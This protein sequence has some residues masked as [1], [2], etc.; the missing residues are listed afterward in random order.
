MSRKRRENADVYALR[1]RIVGLGETS[2]RKSHYPELQA[3]L[4]E[5]AASRDELDRTS[6]DL[7]RMVEELEEARRQAESNEER[8]RHIF[9]QATDGIVVVRLA[10]SRVVLANRQMARQLGCEPEFLVG[11]PAARLGL[12]AACREFV[13]EAPR[14]PCGTS[15]HL[16]GVT[17]PRFD[18]GSLEADVNAVLVEL[19][20]E[21]H[22][23]SIC[24][25]VGEQRRAELRL[26]QLSQ[27][28]E[29]SPAAVVITDGDGR[30]EYVNPAFTRMSGWSAEEVVGCGLERLHSGVT[31]DSVYED[32]HRTVSAGG[33]WRG[34]LCSQRR[35]GVRYW[36]DVTVAAIVDDDGRVIHHHSISV[37]ITEQ[38]ELEQR[39][40]QSQKMEAVGHLAGGV[41]HDF[42]NLLTVINGYS[43]ILLAKLSPGDMPWDGL[44]EIRKAGRRAQS[45]TRQLLAF[46]RKQV[47]RP[48]RL[49]LN[50]LLG[51]MEKMLGRL[52]G[53]DIEFVFSLDPDLMMVKADPGQLEQVLLNLV[54]N[55]RDAMPGGGAMRIETCNAIA[56]DSGD[57]LEERLVGPCVRLAVSD[58]G[59]GMDEATRARIFEPFFTT[60][61][62]GKGTGLGLSTVYGIVHQSGGRILVHSEPGQGTCFEILLPADGGSAPGQG[63]AGD[64]SR[65]R[66]S[67]AIL[68][69][70]DDKAV[71]GLIEQLLTR[72]GYHVRLAAEPE[73][74]LRLLR[75]MAEE[76]PDLV[77]SDVVMPGM[78]G[79]EM[80]RLMRERRPG[81]RVLFMSGYSEHF[82]LREGGPAKGETCLQKPFSTDQLLRELRKALDG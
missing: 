39:F 75:E 53:E 73:E 63:E 45:L 37:D 72:Y 74:G 5:L 76:P 82:L 79:I 30:V 28:V 18:G 33:S 34:E 27:S 21:R 9:D 68:V 60:K 52:I 58:T 56:D 54:V 62:Q 48:V 49:D 11:L 57:T 59:S 38:K 4:Q 22:A 26:R 51:D 12:D 17:I 64:A 78:S 20:G 32:L 42:N 50:L 8:F 1:D 15:R 23:L 69:V 3:Q 80:A 29:Q 13:S 46:S 67:E 6:R 36:E 10:E 44:L 2:L 61:E 55:A 14:L 40:F 25:D 16:S 70:E 7:R 65:P 77:L 47:L 19:D 43:E 41:A 35:D 66:G 81:L 24:R 31:P 71:R